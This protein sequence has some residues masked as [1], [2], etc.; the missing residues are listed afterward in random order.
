MPLTRRQ[1]IL[2]NAYPLAVVRT[3]AAFEALK[4]RIK[5][6]M[7]DPQKVGGKT[8]IYNATAYSKACKAKA[9]ALLREALPQLKKGE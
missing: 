4:A 8:A 6:Y 1:V 2:L 3:H 7:R 5:E 9:D